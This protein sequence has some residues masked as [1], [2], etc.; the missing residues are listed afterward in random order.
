MVGN[1]ISSILKNEK[2]IGDMMLQKGFVSI[3]SQSG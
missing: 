1:P 3:T 2:F